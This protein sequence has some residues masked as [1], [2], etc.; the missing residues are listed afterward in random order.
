MLLFH[1]CRVD[2]W[3]EKIKLLGFDI[4]YAK[5][6]RYGTG[7]YFAI[8]S[9]YSTN[10]FDC[11]NSDGS[12]SMFVAKVLIGDPYIVEEHKLQKEFRKFN[13]FVKPPIKDIN[14]D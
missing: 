6:G 12:F 8:N 1:G 14:K 4:Q 9:N 2:T 5:A 3:A 11:K 13:G 7:L 10:G